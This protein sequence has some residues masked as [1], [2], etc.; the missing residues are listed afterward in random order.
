LTDITKCT[1]GEALLPWIAP[2]CNHFYW[3]AQS[4]PD[5]N[6]RVILAKFQSF[7]SHII[8]KHNDLDNPLF[9]QCQHGPIQ[10][11]MWLKESM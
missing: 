3:S 7:L 10:G 1:G 9:N 4:T 6:G 8:D 5:G 2:C 11:R